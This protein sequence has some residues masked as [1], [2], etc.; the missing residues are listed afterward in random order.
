MFDMPNIREVKRGEY[1]TCWNRVI[2]C[3]YSASSPPLAKMTSASAMSSRPWALSFCF[4][5][6]SSVIIAMMVQ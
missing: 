5:E 2:A 6:Y 1:R 4:F 3:L